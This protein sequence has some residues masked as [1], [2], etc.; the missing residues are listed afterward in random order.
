VFHGEWNF[1]APSL[2]EAR[3]GPA[4]RRPDDLGGR[5]ARRGP[6]LPVC[7]SG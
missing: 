6:G 5:P 7:V 2:T 1:T 4:G 3:M